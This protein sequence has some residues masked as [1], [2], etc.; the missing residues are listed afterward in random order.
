MARTLRCW[1][2]LA[3]LC[4]AA[5]V[6]FADAADLNEALKQADARKRAAENGAR[7][8]RAQAPQDIEQTNAVYAA[9]ADANS[10]WLDAIARGDAPGAAAASSVAASRLVQWVVARN[11]ALGEPVMSETL[12]KGVTE[13][14]QQELADIAK[15]AVAKKRQ[16]TAD[17]LNARLRWKAWEELQETGVNP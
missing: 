11:R 13:R 1:S 12:A 16:D 10:A 9:A 3:I 8:I 14:V 5:S 4:L 2:Y 17:T 6:T 7:A 15:N